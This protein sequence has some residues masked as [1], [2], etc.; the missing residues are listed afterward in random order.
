[1]SFWEK[2][3]PFKRVTHCHV[4]L[5]AGNTATMDTVGGI[6]TGMV[7]HPENEKLVIE[8]TGVVVDSTMDNDLFEE[9]LDAIDEA[10]KVLNEKVKEI[11]RRQVE[12]KDQLER[13][14]KILADF[15]PETG[16]TMKMEPG[17]VFSFWEGEDAGIT[18]YGHRDKEEFAAEI[19]RYDDYQS[20]MRGSSQHPESEIDHRW[21]RAV[22]RHGEIEVQVCDRHDSG[23]FPI[24]IVWN[25]R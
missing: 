3:N 12:T 8:F 22:L 6:I 14:K 11:H 17:L 23:A 13:D 1:M 24:T 20:G 2:I 21:G 25:T 19:Q 5:I 7:E 15:D 9:Y 16:M 10:Q 18:A 4:P